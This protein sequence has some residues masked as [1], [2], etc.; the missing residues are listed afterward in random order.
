VLLVTRAAMGSRIALL[1]IPVFVALDLGW[2]GYS[3]AWSNPAETIVQI[4]SRAE[5][6]PAFGTGTMVHDPSLDKRRNL[7]LL[8]GLKLFRPYVGL[9]PSRVLPV[10]EPRTLRLAG[11]EWVKAGPEWQRV[12]A[13]MPRVRLL[14]EA[15]ESANPARDL[16]TIDIA[17]TALVSAAAPVLDS[18]GQGRAEIVV[19]QPGRLEVD[20]ALS[21]RAILA[22]TE[23]YHQGWRGAGSERALPTLRLYGDYL[24]V[25]LEPGEYRVILTFSPASSRYGVLFSI[26]GLFIAFG[27]AAVLGRAAAK[28][29]A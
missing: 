14:F 16:D 24:G 8:R 1:L 7:V 13:P 23:S 18:R 27:L 20:I 19:D 17:R 25:L 21:G 5:P 3:Y 22:T 26:L 15:L 2:W 10:D 6:P 11:V 12:A 29:P 28:R 9:A 4:T